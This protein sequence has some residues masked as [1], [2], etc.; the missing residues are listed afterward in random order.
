MRLLA[1]TLTFAVLSLGF[2]PAPF[3]KAQRREDAGG[4]VGLWQ[5][6]ESFMQITS[7]KLFF[8]SAPHAAYELRVDRNARPAAYDLRGVKGNVAERTQIQGIYKVEGDVLTTCDA[9]R[10]DPR[11]TAFDPKAGCV[12]VYTRVRR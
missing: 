3:P 8:L 11:P 4:M 7:T 9:A 10:N 2:A 1:V 12:N 5:S 6:G